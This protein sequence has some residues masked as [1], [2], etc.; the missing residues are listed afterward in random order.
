MNQGKGL[1]AT[2]ALLAAVAAL[3]VLRY[4]PPAALPA[5]APADRFSAGRG[6]VILQHLVGES[7]PHPT[8]SPENG[9]VRD[10]I[11][12]LLRSWGYEPQI[13]RTLAC[14]R[15]GACAYV[16]NVVARLK[17][18]S[19]GSAVLVAVHYDSV[20]AGPGASD[21]GVGTA[22]ALEVARLLRAGPPPR[23]DV[24]FLIDDGEEQGLLGARAFAEQ[25]PWAKEVRAVVNL[26]AR[27]TSGASLMFET[28]RSNRWVIGQVARSVPRPATNSIYYTIYTLLPNDTDFSIFKE[29]PWQGV[30]FAFV[31]DAARYH[32]PLDNFAFADPR[33]LQHHGDNLLAMTRAFANA[34]LR[35]P[36]GGNVVFFDFFTLGIVRW[37]EAWN[38]LFAGITAI[39]FL[40]A[41]GRQ[42]RRGF[43]RIRDVALGVLVWI[44]AVLAG[45]LLGYL[46]YTALR[47]LGAYP[48][49]W[50]AHP[51]PHVVAFW[52]IGIAACGF[53][54][55]LF[56]QRNPVGVWAGVWLVWLIAGIVL[57][58]MHPGMSYPF[59]VPVFAAAF[60]GLF[61]GD[62]RF[63]S[64][65]I[66]LPLVTGACLLFPIAWLLYDGMGA[67]ILPA[68]AL[69]VTVVLTGLVPLLVQ[70]GR[71]VAV[72]VGC[73]GLAAVIAAA[74]AGALLPKVSP[75]T[76]AAAPIVCYFDTDA[77]RGLIVVENETV[78]VPRLPDF[79]LSTPYPWAH[80]ARALTAPL[81]AA[82]PEPPRFDV[83]ERATVPGGFRVAGVLTSPRGAARAA[84]F[85]PADRVETVSVE[86]QPVR[87]GRR[88]D[89]STRGAW[90]GF[91]FVNLPAEGVRYDVTFRGAGPVDVHLWDSTPGVLPEANGAVTARGRDAVTIESGDRVL[92]SRRM[93]L[94]PVAD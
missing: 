11:V 67:G 69:L 20:G 28:N 56:A 78:M 92:V 6:Q 65:A 24:I 34:E 81:N 31:G 42:I 22:A 51:T 14:G 48:V 52:S 82:S 84:V 36:V 29:Y 62:E 71:R 63:F 33:S 55:A 44:S 61:V 23:N 12:A 10:R 88:K 94:A 32:T 35:S 37:P 41:L 58:F 86:G 60:A 59:L 80:S 54:A 38:P 46:I 47:S 64:F 87:I 5:D 4:A 2:G 50:V 83:I 89:G 57:A 77:D 45:A 70:C 85:F 43:L 15:N 39:L 72:L 8:G 13:Q 73:A 53:I 18:Q 7:V 40:L 68:V 27:G 3:S 19:S 75:E 25:H 66:A 93:M 17:G 49:Q 9:R 91:R 1:I 79:V 74:V 21:D 76:P 26:E 30:N 90:R 16:E